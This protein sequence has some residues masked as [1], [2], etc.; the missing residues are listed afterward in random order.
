MFPCSSIAVVMDIDGR[1]QRFYD[2]HRKDI[3]AVAIYPSGAIVA[4]G[5]NAE[6]PQI[7]IWDLTNMETLAI[8]PHKYHDNGIT[9]LAFSPDAGKQLV[10]CGNDMLHKVVVWEWKNK[11][12]PIYASLDMKEKVN[13]LQ[14]NPVDE[15]VVA[16]G[17]GMINFIRIAPKVGIMVGNEGKYIDPT[18]QVDVATSF[19]R[20]C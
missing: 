20:D 8:L 15:S 16:C 14:Y 18:E 11:R 9:G 6:Q 4:T 1:K 13:C 5:E 17:N 12:K 19:C 7:I 10:S 3:S 2:G